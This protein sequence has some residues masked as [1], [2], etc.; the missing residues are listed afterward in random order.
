MIDSEEVCEVA[1]RGWG[2]VAGHQEREPTRKLFR[3]SHRESADPQDCSSRVIY[4]VPLSQIHLPIEIKTCMKGGDDRIIG[5]FSIGSILEPANRSSE[6][7]SE[8]LWIGNIS[9]NPG[10]IVNL[11]VCSKNGDKLV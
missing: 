3:F 7:D 8:R 5:G 11:G 6:S 2:C 4:P 1:V 10:N 9:E